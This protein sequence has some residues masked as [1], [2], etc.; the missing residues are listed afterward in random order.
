MINRHES[1]QGVSKHSP[2]VRIV[3]GRSAIKLAA[4]LAS[5]SHVPRMMRTADER[6]FMLMN[7][8]ALS[9][10]IGVHLWF[11]TSAFFSSRHRGNHRDAET[12]RSA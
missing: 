1:P 3:A 9:A 4:A 8:F 5:Q 12:L 11:V 2:K 6:R 7:S 10:F